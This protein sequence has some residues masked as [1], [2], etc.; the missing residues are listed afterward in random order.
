MA[1]WGVARSTIELMCVNANFK[2]YSKD[3]TYFEFMFD[4]VKGEMR[5][6][7]DQTPGVGYKPVL[8]F[9]LF[10]IAERACRVQSG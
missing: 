1:F 3:K 7:E 4:V 6:G 9:Q 8:L 2:K 10:Y 5:W